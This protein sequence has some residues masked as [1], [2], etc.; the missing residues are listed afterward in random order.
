MNGMKVGG[1]DHIAPFP[2]TLGGKLPYDA[3][4][5]PSGPAL[6]M[7][8]PAFGGQPRRNKRWN[9]RRRELAQ[10]SGQR[11]MEN[12]AEQP[13]AVVPAV[14]LVA[15]TDVYP[16]AVKL[17][18]GRTGVDPRRK[19]ILEKWPHVEVVVPF[20]IDDVYAGC[21]ERP[22]LFQHRRI[23]GEGVTDPELEQVAH[24]KQGIRDAP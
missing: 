12:E 5:V 11:V 15:M 7:I 19:G 6:V 23:V 3:C 21:M 10:Q 18:Y 13:V 24:Y 1:Y 22:K 8:T 9:S 14:N 2:E 16:L 20:E 17:Y 4:V